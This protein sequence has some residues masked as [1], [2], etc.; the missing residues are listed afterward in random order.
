MVVLADRGVRHPGR[1]TV[2]VHDGT[3]GVMD[4]RQFLAVAR[5]VVQGQTEAHW[6]SATGRAYYSL[7][8]ELRDAFIRWGL[9][10][11]SRASLHQAVL[12]R[13]Y[14]STDGDMK[15]IGRWLE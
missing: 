14:T 13:A 3:G 8:L 1:R 6:R 5:E 4:G 12:R 10:A 9:S 2:P 15:Q 7:M 11:P